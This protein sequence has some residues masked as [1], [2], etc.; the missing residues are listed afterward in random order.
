MR[1][2]EKVWH[3]LFTGISRNFT[4]LIGISK[5]IRG[6]LGYGYTEVSYLDMIENALICVYIKRL[7]CPNQFMHPV[8]MSK[9]AMQR[10]YWNSPSKHFCTGDSD[11]FQLSCT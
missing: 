6:V 5:D 7:G 11:P 1:K 2:S 4:L 3:I 8:H 10:N 9:Q